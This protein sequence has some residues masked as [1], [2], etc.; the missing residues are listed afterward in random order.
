MKQANATIAKAEAGGVPAPLFRMLDPLIDDRPADERVA[1]SMRQVCRLATIATETGAR[2]A[3]DRLREDALAWLYTPRA[4]FSGRCA[5]EACL[6]TRAFRHALVLH[7]LSLG[8][9]AVADDLDDLLEPVDA[10]DTFDEIQ[11][12]PSPI[13]P[14]PVQVRRRQLFTATILDE[15]ERGTLQAFVAVVADDA[16]DVFEHLRDRYGTR[17]ADKA[18]I[19]PGFDP[20]EPIAMALVSEAVADALALIEAEADSSL[21]A[22]V[23]VQLES[24]FLH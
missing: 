24:R 13:F 17:I 1:L 2:F 8:L 5:V 7:G 4:L 12:A 11:R 22:G 21:A 18:V 14:R 19:R 23:D 15:S 20:S 3:R 16:L 6:E 10:G 9:D